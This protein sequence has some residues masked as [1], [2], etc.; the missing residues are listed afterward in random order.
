MDRTA[1]VP[2]EDTMTDGATTADTSTPAA[3]AKQADPGRTA[4]GGV[5]TRASLRELLG[6]VLISDSDLTGFSLDHYAEK[7]HSGFTDGMDRKA[8][9]NIL[10]A[11]ASPTSILG[12]LRQRHR[13]DVAKH[14]HV[15]RDLP[16]I[17]ETPARRAAVAAAAFALAAMAL[18]LW[19]YWIPFIPPFA[20]GARGIVI[21]GR[22]VATRDGDTVCGNL[23]KLDPR[24]DVVC[25]PA[26]FLWTGLET[27]LQR[28]AE[29]AG[30]LV[31]AT[32]QDDEM[33]LRPLGQLAH[34]PLFAAGV[35]VHLRTVHDL[36]NVTTLFR[37]MA[38][39]AAPETTADEAN[40]IPCPDFGAN[41]LDEAG[42]LTLRLV[43][44]CEGVALGRAQYLGF[45][46]PGPES[47]ANEA[48]ALGRH[49]FAEAHPGDPETRDFLTRLRDRGPPRFREPA[50]L[51]LALSDCAQGRL[52]DAVRAV[53]ELSEGASR[54]LDIQLAGIAAC[55]AFKAA[56]PLED[57]LARL[58]EVRVGEDDARVCT[59]E[60]I[61][62]ALATRGYWRLQAKQWDKA[63][64]AYTQAYPHKK[65]PLFP[66]SAAEALLELGEH[67]AEVQR[68][69]DL[70]RQ[71]KAELDA[72]RAT[73]G[74]AP[75]PRDRTVTVYAALLR[76]AVARQRPDVRAR[77][78]AGE[79][80]RRLY[81][82]L[83]EHTPVIADRDADPGLRRL[84][85]GELGP[86]CV[87]D[88]LE[89]DSPRAL[90]EILRAAPP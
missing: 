25:A 76:W 51:T 6:L 32:V 74:V 84:V 20:P 17:V 45:C 80:L 65:D 55:I 81:D 21:A 40:S 61:G 42:L 85:C 27:Y 14:E 53:H 63:A 70:G 43:P 46:G 36:G 75:S 23:R 52:D 88:A 49:L 8:K 58:D 71:R 19:M 67:P 82:G 11:R 4:R 77:E 90:D 31:V 38:R 64:A 13:D 24:R 35:T 87:Y 22:W 3:A 69:L 44:A 56:S 47:D 50:K 68:L 79:E 15:L 16:A 1:G 60:Q 12:N 2:W 57:R 9:V 73:Y 59:G 5:P 83:P 26:R 18:V 86:P 28:R 72:L 48:C 29:D 41:A 30:A 10:L 34:N 7:V 39:A 37:A 78:D 33:H 89:R 66:L 62:D 54:C